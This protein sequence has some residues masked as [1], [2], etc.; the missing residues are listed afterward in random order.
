MVRAALR[1]ARGLAR[2]LIRPSSEKQW[3][4]RVAL[5]GRRAVLNLGHPEE[6]YET[7]TEMQRRE[8]LP[9]L[10][11]SIGP[12]DRTALDFGCGPGR[13]TRDLAAVTGGEAIGVD[14]V[15]ELLDLA[16]PSPSVVYRLMKEGAIPLPSESVDVAWICLVLGGLEGDALE[17]SAR[18]IGRVLRP[19]G[20]LFLIENTSE[21][22]N[23]ESWRFRS[24]DA[25]RALFPFVN[26]ERRHDYEDL[27][28]RI[29]IM[30]GRKET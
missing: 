5:Y 1:R 11:R 13:F 22:P 3:R 9:H 27:A 7:V 2:R 23:T 20:L 25:Y 4:A 10:R 12:H 30:A 15:Q 8:I 17:G 28:E 18:E 24:I 26:L 29:T 14:V 21:K 19:G 16:P 6:D